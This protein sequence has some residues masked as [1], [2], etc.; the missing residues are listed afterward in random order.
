MFTILNQ[1]TYEIEKNLYSSSISD[2]TQDE[3]EKI[4]KQIERE[5][6]WYTPIELLYFIAVDWRITITLIKYIMSL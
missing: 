2:L 3:I 6:K 1:E 4:K 5:K